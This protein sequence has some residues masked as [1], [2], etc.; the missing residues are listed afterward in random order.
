MLIINQHSGNHLMIIYEKHSKKIRDYLGIFPK[1]RTI[2]YRIFL[3]KLKF[4]GNFWVILRCFKGFFRALVKIT[5]VLGIGKTPPYVGKNSQIIPYF[6]LKASRRM[7]GRIH[8]WGRGW[9]SSHISRFWRF[10]LPRSQWGSLKK[11]PK[12]EGFCAIITTCLIESPFSKSW[13]QSTTKNQLGWTIS[14][15]QQS[16]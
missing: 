5:K 14:Q 6:F 12:S 1:H 3:V 4:F 13:E 7:L 15:W 16:W 9:A 11:R 8:L 10:S 2:F